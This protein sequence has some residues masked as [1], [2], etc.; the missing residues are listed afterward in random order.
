[1]AE[2]GQKELK[3]ETHLKVYCL[4][5]KVYCLNPFR[6]CLTVRMDSDIADRLNGFRHCL[7]R[8]RQHR[9]KG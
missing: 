4:N 8:F 9:L 1:M 7:N 2:K 3:L 6:H 5:F